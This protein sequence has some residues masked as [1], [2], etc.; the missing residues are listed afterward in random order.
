M[1]DLEKIH[2]NGYAFQIEMAYRVS[3]A[4]NR[5]GEIPIIFYERTS[6]SSKMSKDIIREAAVLPW[7]LRLAG[8][9]RAD[10]RRAFADFKYDI[11]TVLGFLT[12]LAGI[13]GGIGLGAWLSTG[14][15]R[16]IT[17]FKMGLPIGP[18]VDEIG[19]ASLVSSL[20]CF[21][22]PSLSSGDMAV[23]KSV[24]IFGMIRPSFSPAR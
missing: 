6:G 17:N 19:L 16:T 14:T 8:L 23:S 5:V 21:L 22:A 15:Y 7:R 13:A 18:A 1:I 24:Q 4:G 11:R 9:F 12:V 2:S 20:S 10:R 3:A